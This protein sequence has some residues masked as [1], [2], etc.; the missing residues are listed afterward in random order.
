[1][2]GIA[3][4]EGVNR[5]A[6]L[7]DAGGR[8]CPAKG[9]LDAFDGHRGCGCGA[10]IAASSQGGKDENWVSVG[11]PIAPKQAKG[12]MRKWHVAILGALAPMDMNHHSLAID[13]GD[14]QV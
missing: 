13:I 10:F 9:S 3:M 8:L 4:A 14:V 12:L 11:E 5:Y 1:V 6:S 2:G 7:V